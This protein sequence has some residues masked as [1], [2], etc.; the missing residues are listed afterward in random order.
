MSQQ[1]SSH[2]GGLQQILSIFGGTIAYLW[3]FEK[4]YEILATRK[5]YYSTTI[6]EK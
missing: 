3:N 1:E 5:V 4:K 2:F 6:A